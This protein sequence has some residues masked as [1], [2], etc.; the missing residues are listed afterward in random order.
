MLGALGGC[1]WDGRLLTQQQA[2]HAARDLNLGIDVA[3]EDDAYPEF[4]AGDENEG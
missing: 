1:L 4:E 2:N 3:I